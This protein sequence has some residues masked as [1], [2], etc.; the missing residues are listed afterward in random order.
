MM[1]CGSTMKKSGINTK[2]KTRAL[3]SCFY[4]QI[5]C[6]VIS[7]ESGLRCEIRSMFSSMVF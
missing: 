5:P 1:I 7:I 6:I 3:R 4:L 2:I